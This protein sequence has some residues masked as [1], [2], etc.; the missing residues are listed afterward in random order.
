MQA[1]G[2]CVDFF[3]QDVKGSPYTL[4]M[5]IPP[6]TAQVCP[7]TYAAAGEARNTAT[8]P[9]SFRRPTRPSGTVLAAEASRYR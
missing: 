1:V 4:F 9:T 8:Y 7:V 3:F 2:R 5:L 6:S